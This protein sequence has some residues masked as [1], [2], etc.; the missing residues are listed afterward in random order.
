MKRSLDTNDEKPLKERKGKAKSRLNGPLES[1]EPTILERDEKSTNKVESDQDDYVVNNH[2]ESI[3]LESDFELDQTE[4]PHPRKRLKT[5]T[6]EKTVVKKKRIKTPLN[7]DDEESHSKISGSRPSAEFI[8]QHLL[9]LAEH[10]FHFVH[11]IRRMPDSPERWT[12]NFSALSC[13][14]QKH[15]LE[16]MIFARYQKEG[17]RIIRILQ[18]KGKL[19][20]KAISDFGLMNQKIMRSTLNKM[21]ANG[22]LELQE[23]PRDNQRQTSKTIHLWHYDQKRCSQKVLEETYQTM[24]RVMQRI[25]VEREHARI[26][27]EKSERS[28]VKG[29]ENELL[30]LEERTQLSD[31]KKKEEKLLVQLG[32]LD[33]L[34]FVL[35]D[36]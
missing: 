2:D 33:D 24:A 29:R 20:E 30:T 21:H 11:H 13:Q 4:S 15:E 10:P 17:L 1:S 3:A 6:G 25:K 27:I 18:E 16:E 31:W 12:V 9:L 19:E 34:V 26:V 23:V 32:R 7:S 5:S 22:H 28:D 36:F 8:R 35:R 14:L